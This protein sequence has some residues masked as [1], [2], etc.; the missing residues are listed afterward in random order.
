T[1]IRHLVIDVSSK[2][3][4]TYY[5]PLTGRVDCAETAITHN[6]TEI[7]KRLTSTLVDSAITG[8]CYQS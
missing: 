2:V 1:N 7:S 3:S 4:Q 5:N 6:A 8:K